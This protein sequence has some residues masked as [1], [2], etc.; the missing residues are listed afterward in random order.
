MCLVRAR[1]LIVPL[2]CAR[3]PER[4]AA[5]P[6]AAAQSLLDV[7]DS[8]RLPSRAQYFP[9][10]APFTMSL[11]RER[12]ATSS[13]SRLFSFSRLSRSPVHRAIFPLPLVVSLL[14]DANVAGGV[15]DRSPLGPSGFNLA[16][17]RD[18]LIRGVTSPLHGRSGDWSSQITCALDQFLAGT[19]RPVNIG[20]KL[21]IPSN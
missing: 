15:P 11:S 12:A 9:S 6:F 8:N 7:L 13:F 5:P 16:Q 18:N 14:S 19:S 4:S 20:V 17:L 1:V 2:H 3:L 10:S 21:S